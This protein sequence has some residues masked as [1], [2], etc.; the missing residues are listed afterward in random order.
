MTEELTPMD[1]TQCQAEIC[2]AHGSFILGPKPRFVRCKERPIYLAREKNPGP[3]GL[4]GEMSL[5]QACKEEL[6]R[7]RADVDISPLV[8]Y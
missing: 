7:Q 8:E 1:P 2:V 4:R 3:D 6:M 5:C